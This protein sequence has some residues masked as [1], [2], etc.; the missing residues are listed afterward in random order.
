METIVNWVVEDIE[1]FHQVK[2]ASDDA[3]MNSAN[4]PTALEVDCEN[5][6]TAT[7]SDL[8]LSFYKDR[9]KGKIHKIKNIISSKS[10]HVNLNFKIIIE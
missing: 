2:H 10:S 5:T 4:S 6:E 8:S 7:R 1:S 9:I 3:S